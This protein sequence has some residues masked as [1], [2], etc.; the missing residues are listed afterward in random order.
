M[1]NIFGIRRSDPPEELVSISDRGAEA[2]IDILVL[3]LE[4]TSPGFRFLTLVSLSFPAL[5]TLLPLM[6]PER[7]HL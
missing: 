3:G 7:V 5:G 6:K 4:E 1:A 2:L